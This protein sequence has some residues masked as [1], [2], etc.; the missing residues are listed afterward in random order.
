MADKATIVEVAERAGTSLST[1]SRVLSNSSYPVSAE[2]KKRVL[3]ASEALGYIPNNAAR[4]LR[5][6]RGMY[7]AVIVPSLNNPFYSSIISAIER[8]VLSSGYMMQ[9]YSS[10]NVAELENRILDLIGSV[11]AAAILISSINWDEKL[12]KKVRELGIPAVF[13]DQIPNGI[14]GHFIGFDF[15]KAGM[16][17]AEFLIS[18]GHR[19]IVFGCG[20]FDRESRKLYRDGFS[21][22]LSSS[23]IDCSGAV[24]SVENRKGMNEYEMGIAIAEAVL[25]REK[26]PTAIAVIND[27]AAFGVMKRL[28]A[29]GLNVPADISVIG[30]DDIP[31]GFMISPSL[32]TIRQP[33]AETGSMAAKLAIDLVNNPEGEYSNE[34]FQPVLIKRESVRRLR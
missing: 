34:V 33:A 9:L 22:V 32:T 16:M 12:E 24:I 31:Y 25:H 19:D 1:V 28:E 5:S 29:E 15:R 11:R 7:I 4:S 20:P 3:E 10:D 6:K 23:S 17:A 26:L 13:F 2:T 8:E 27:I 21:E 18:E 14:T 30:F